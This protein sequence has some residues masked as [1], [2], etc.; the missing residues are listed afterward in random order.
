MTKHQ[1]ILSFL[2]AI[3]TGC[4]DPLVD[5]E[6]AGENVFGDPS[7]APADAPHVEDDP[8]FA[9]RLSSF[10]QNV[11]YLQAFAEGER[12]RYWNVDGANA[13][14]IAP[15]FLVEGSSRAIIDVIPGEIGYSPWWRIVTVKT[16][17][18]Y[19]GQRIWSR[20]AIEAGVRLGILEEPVDTDQVVSCPVALRG[21]EVPLGMSRTATTSWVWYR[22][23]RV[24]WIRFNDQTTVP[25]DQREMPI[26]PVYVFQRINEA[27]PIYEFVTRVDVNGDGILDA[28]N[29]VF[30]SK[31]GG[32]RYSPLWF[33][34]FVRTSAD[35]RSVDS[36]TTTIDV[37]REED[38]VGDQRSPKVLSVMDH[39]D[40]LVNCPI[41][42]TEGEL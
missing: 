19:A 7:I 22:N 24:D 12:V 27:L 1:A 6:I 25:V 30:S 31:P 23:M 9:D 35:L 29:N 18:S 21:T 28:S 39:E 3:S 16:T 34:S 4:L 14:F 5:D 2:L 20:A 36:S 10:T 33:F 40:Q 41:Q 8:A 26:F 17:S 11:A 15:M 42:R 13:S 32:Y 37:T 38:I